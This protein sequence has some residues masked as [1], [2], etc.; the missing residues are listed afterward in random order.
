MLNLVVNLPLA[1]WHVAD[2][3]CVNQ[4]LIFII[5]S[6]LSEQDIVIIVYQFDTKQIR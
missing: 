6:Q 4:D 1:A 3:G 5:G 2:I